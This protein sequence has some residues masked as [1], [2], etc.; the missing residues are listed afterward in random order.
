MRNLTFSLLLLLLL[1]CY[2]PAFAL[3]PEFSQA[4][5]GDVVACGVFKGDENYKKLMLT[6]EDDPE[7]VAFVVG[8]SAYEEIDRDLK[9]AARD[10]NQI[11][12]KF[13]LLGFDVYL[14]LNS[15]KSEALLCYKDYLET[16]KN[17]HIRTVYFS[18]HALQKDGENF[19]LFYD[20]D[21]ELETDMGIVPL[22]TFME[23]PTN[24]QKQ[25]TVLF[26]DACRPLPENIESKPGLAAVGKGDQPVG[27]YLSYSAA[28][29][30]LAEDGEGRNSPFAA[31]MLANIGIPGIPL[32]KLGEVIANDVGET[33]NWEQTPWRRSSLTDTI[34]FNGDRTTEDAAKEANLAATAVAEKLLIGERD[35]AL[36]VAAGAMPPMWHD[37][38]REEF[39][40]VRIALRRAIATKFVRVDGQSYDDRYAYSSETDRIAIYADQKL[41]LFNTERDLIATLLSEG[42]LSSPN[43][44]N[45][46]P[47]FSGDG[48]ILAAPTNTGTVELWNSEDG[49]HLMSLQNAFDPNWSIPSV[50]ISRSGE[51]LVLHSSPRDHLSIYKLSFGSSAPQSKLVNNLSSNGGGFSNLI[52]SNRNNMLFFTE[53][54]NQMGKDRKFSNNSRAYFVNLEN[55]VVSSGIYVHKSD[56]F[57]DSSSDTAAGGALDESGSYYVIQDSHLPDNGFDLH[58]WDVHANTVSTI[59]ENNKE[60]V[61]PAFIDGERR[62]ALGNYFDYDIYDIETGRI[63]VLDEE[64]Y[65]IYSTRIFSTGVTAFPIVK[66]LRRSFNEQYFWDLIEQLR[67]EQNGLSFGYPFY[68]LQ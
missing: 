2:L 52:I 47:V 25:N 3:V 67:Q 63:S 9:N 10:A 12:D 4:T 51:Y 41:Q 56:S 32:T 1:N 27:Y 62:I 29:N 28:P 17:A 5:N 38:S 60:F 45:F 46:S 7:R 53:Y 61:F 6:D 54:T 36:R 42:E 16:A 34:Y 66:I 30:S 64:E 37:A 55:G 50:I 39:R 57:Q 22:S 44:I 26:L 49:S 20:F 31:A 19:L 11:A 24:G 40:S 35:E 15:T 14:S 65:L 8:I 21:S 23:M 13:S 59:I 43:L 48:R 18:G 68:T 33:T 58:I